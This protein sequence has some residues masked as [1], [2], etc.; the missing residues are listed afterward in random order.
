VPRPD[1]A[2]VRDG[3]A[4]VFL[5]AKY[6]DVWSLGCPPGWLYQLAVYAVG[7]FER[8]AV[9]LY[10]TEHAAALEERIQLFE[11]GRSG[12]SA[13]VVLRPVHLGRVG[14]LLARLMERTQTQAAADFATGLVRC[15]S[16]H[17]PRL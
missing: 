17:V 13:T 5:D 10:P 4:Q 1:F 6:R 16:D 7:S 2:L 11:F 3:R 14:K 15:A 8:T 9:M 12:A